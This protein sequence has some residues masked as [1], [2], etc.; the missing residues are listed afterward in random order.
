M[1]NDGEICETFACG[2]WGSRFDQITRPGIISPREGFQR[3]GVSLNNIGTDGMSSLEGIAGGREVPVQDGREQQNGPRQGEERR[4]QGADRD[5]VDERDRGEVQEGTRQVRQEALSPFSVYQ[6]PVK[7]T[8]P[9]SPAFSTPIAT[10]G[11][12]YIPKRRRLDLQ[13]SSPL[14]KVPM[15]SPNDRHA[16]PQ[17]ANRSFTTPI[18][19]GNTS[20]GLVSNGKR[21]PSLQDRPIPVLSPP[22]AQSLDSQVSRLSDIPSTPMSASSSSESS[23]GSI[24]R[25]TRRVVTMPILSTDPEKSSPDTTNTSSTSATSTTSGVSA[26]GVSSPKSRMSGLGENGLRNQVGK[27]VGL[28]RLLNDQWEV[29]PIENG[30]PPVECIETIRQQAQKAVEQLA[31]QVRKADSQD[32]EMRELV[33]RFNC[34]SDQ[35]D[36]LSFYTVDQVYPEYNRQELEPAED[37]EVVQ[38]LDELTVDWRLLFHEA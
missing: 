28:I 19:V 35:L 15:S 17:K 33:E 8:P 32:I 21:T 11:S 4:E 31:G 10:G 30:P 3:R 1:K 9:V 7:K 16:T 23:A 27:W 14:M 24:P 34:G 13:T 29:P 22:S 38:L 26:S 36:S 2:S 37:T 20:V 6:S 12:L 25:R 5:E 18:R